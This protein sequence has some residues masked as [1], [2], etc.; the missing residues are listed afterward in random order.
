MCLGTRKYPL[1]SSP[2]EP[3]VLHP[4]L[5]LQDLV[6]A[7]TPEPPRVQSGCSVSWVQTLA[8]LCDLEQFDQAL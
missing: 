5:V 6:E 2:Q 7:T 1:S 8:L 4:W 3:Q